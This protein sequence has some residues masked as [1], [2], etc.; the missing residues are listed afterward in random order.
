MIRSTTC[1]LT[2]WGFDCE[3]HITFTY[4]PGRPGTWYKRNGDPGDPPEPDELDIESVK[5]DGS[6]VPELSDRQWA[7]VEQ[8]CYDAV[9]GD[10]EDREAEADE[11]RAALR[12]D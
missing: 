1:R 9:A 12:D 11:Y 2:L 8:A 7:I 6:E 10:E 5:V 4:S 3:A